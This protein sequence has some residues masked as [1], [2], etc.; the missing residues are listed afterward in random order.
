MLEKVSLSNKRQSSFFLGALSYVPTFPETLLTH[1]M[2]M[3][4]YGP[5]AAEYWKALL[6]M[7]S[8]IKYCFESVYT[9][10]SYSTFQFCLINKPTFLILACRLFTFGFIQSFILTKTKMFSVNMCLICSRIFKFSY[11]KKTKFR[12]VKIF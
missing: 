6:E 2:L 12:V 5:N 7:L 11:R 10:Q 3:F 8:Y 4:P 1:F 9:I